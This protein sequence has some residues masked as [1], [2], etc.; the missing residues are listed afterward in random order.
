MATCERCGRSGWFLS[1]SGNGLCAACADA[2]L[3]EAA[4]KSHAPARH[5]DKLAKA[6]T[7]S[8]D[9]PSADSVEPVP[10]LE[11][12]QPS[13]GFDEYVGQEAI[14][15]DVLARIEAAVYHSRPLP[16]LL[17]S[18]PPEMGKATLA[19]MIAREM[20]V[21]INRIYGPVVGEPADLARSLTE[22][23]ESDLFLIEQIESLKEP[24]LE[25]LMAAIE[26]FTLELPADRE[27]KAR[28]LKF[29]L[30]RFTLVGTTSRPWQVDKRLRRWMIRFDFAPYSVQEIG[31]IVKRIGNLTFDPE[32]ATLVAQ[33]CEGTPGNARVMVKRLRNHVSDYA[34][35]H[36]TVDL[37]KEALVSF[38]YT[39][40]PSIRTDLAS[41]VCSMT[42]VAFKEFAVSLFREMG[43]TVEIT[44]GTTDNGI[45]L[46]LRKNNQLIAV[47]C[48]RCSN[49]V[50]EPVVRDFSSALMS[51]GAQSG[52]ILTTSTFTSHA[53]SFAE[54]KP[55]QLVD[56]EALVDLATRRGSKAPRSGKQKTR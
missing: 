37:A 14:K 4:A 48:R 56:L 31:E 23:E 33:H 52:Y 32:A 34:T 21:N 55:I 29:S 8:S 42:A 2:E 45:D 16:H 9:S 40:K 44:P 51:S 20:K 11:E 41:N 30:K 50:G 1:L 27:P 12:A 17:L 28:S 13:P 7:L 53:Y 5:V 19:H 25:A 3:K 47:Q 6:E 46:L 18:G 43:Y 49:A 15:K 39:S 24:A 22:L 26:D 38:G 36:V 35:D 10:S 54:G